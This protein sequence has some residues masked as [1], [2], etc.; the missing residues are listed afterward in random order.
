MTLLL[1]F[2]ALPLLVFDTILHVPTI[3]IYIVGGVYDFLPLRKKPFS[4]SAGGELLC[5]VTLLI[6]SVA[7]SI[8]RTMR[9]PIVTR[10]H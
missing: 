9:F 8:F 3:L 7:P 4:H 1:L 2:E 5:L 10:P 6:S